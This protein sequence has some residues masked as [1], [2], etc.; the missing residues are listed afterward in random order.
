M[1]NE[2]RNHHPLLAMWHFTVHIFVGVF[3]FLVIY[4]P[5]YGLSQL[6]HLLED[7][8]DPV[9]VLVMRGAEY[10]LLFADSAFFAIFVVMSTWRAVKSI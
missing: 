8:T 9:L 6:V 4:L 3:L 2:G 7:G 5:A 1:S 10:L